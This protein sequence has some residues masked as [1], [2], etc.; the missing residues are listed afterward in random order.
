MIL[1]DAGKMVEKWYYELENKYPDIKCKEMIVM[2]NHIHF[3]IQNV[4]AYV[5]RADP[6]VCPPVV[7]ADL[8]VC[9]PAP[10][11]CP[12][13]S[14][15][16]RVVQWFKTMTT[17]AYIRG[18]KNNNWNP[19]DGKLWQRNYWE[20]IIR[21]KNEY[22]RIARYIINNPIKW[23]NDKLNGGRGNTVTEPQAEYNAEI[24]MV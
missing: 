6:R 23:E 2:P 24:W 1:N 18:V 4:G 10:R 22:N 12:P 7:R 8:R 5:V 13:A 19:F 9:P 3:I 11:V 21:N 15:L 14:P 20:H 16:P 17:N